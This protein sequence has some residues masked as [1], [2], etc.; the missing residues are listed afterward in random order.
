MRESAE[1]VCTKVGGGWRGRK[2]TR[3]GVENEEE[4]K[5]EENER[6]TNTQS[7]KTG[8]SQDRIVPC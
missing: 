1:R 6:K 7:N 5:E 4:G 3:V 2:L 8:F